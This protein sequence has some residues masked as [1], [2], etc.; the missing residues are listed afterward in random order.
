MKVS[1]RRIPQKADSSRPTKSVGCVRN[2]NQDRWTARVGLGMTTLVLSLEG[3]EG[4]E[5]VAGFGIV[6]I[7][8][9]SLAQ[10]GSGEVDA[11]GA[12]IK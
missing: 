12:A 5:G 3:G 1:A 2:D 11:A 4:G 10:F 6:G 9:D 8:G 7:K